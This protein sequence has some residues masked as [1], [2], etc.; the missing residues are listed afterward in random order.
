MKK[1][2]LAVTLVMSMIMTGCG[3]ATTSSTSEETTEA[4]A[5]DSSAAASTIQVSEATQKIIDKGVLTVGSSGDVY[6]YI[7]QETGEFAGPDADIIIEAAKRLGIPKVEMSL[8]PFSELIVNLNQDNIDMIADGMYVR[9]DRGE[10]I[11]YG[12]IWYTQGGALLASESGSIDGQTDFDPSKTIVGYTPGTAWQT[13]VEKWAA[14]GKIKEARSTGDQAESIVALQNGKIDAFLT[15]STVVEN[16]MKFQP[17]TLKG[18]KLCS[19]YTDEEGTIGRIAASV[20][21]G[22]E[23]FMNDVNTVVAQ[24]REEGVLDQ[25]FE[26]YGLDPKLHA[27]TNDEK[28]NGLSK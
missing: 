27:I 10:I 7:D 15:D 6:A 22:N 21:F 28:D 17:D 24:M 5:A 13:V 4:T 3:G 11:H 14:D 16:M 9:E 12:D 1:F 23:D 18:L 8:I 26:K 25:I 2:V 19:N 20:K